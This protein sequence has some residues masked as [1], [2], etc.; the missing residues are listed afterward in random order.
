MGVWPNK[1]IKLTCSARKLSAGRRAHPGQIGLEKIVGAS[2]V[3]N[4]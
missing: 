1:R 3:E 2:R 4:G